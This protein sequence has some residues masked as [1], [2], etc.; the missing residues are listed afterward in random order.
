VGGF[1]GRDMLVLRR[2]SCVRRDGV[3]WTDVDAEGFTVGM[4]D[5]CRADFGFWILSFMNEYTL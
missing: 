5:I 4:R 1:R 3:P 2:N